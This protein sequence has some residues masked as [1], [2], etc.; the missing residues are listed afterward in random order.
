MNNSLRLR[1]TVWYVAFFSALFMLFSV[2]LYHT[3]ERDLDKRVNE[4]LTSE[5][6]TVAGF[7]AD[8]ID[9]LKGDVPAAAVETAGVRLGA[10]TIAIL[11][12][13]RVL[14]SAVPVPASLIE[15]VLRRPAGSG[16]ALVPLPAVGRRGSRAAVHPMRVRDREI[17]VLVTRP[18]DSIAADLDLVRRVL[19]FALPLLIAIAGAGGYLVASRSLAPLGAMAEQARRI[20]GSNLDTRLD[21][22]DAAAELTALAASFNELLSRLD[23]SFESMRRFVADAS[24]ELRTPLAVIRAEA[25]LTLDRERDPAEYRASL[26]VILDES[27]RLSRLIDDL[28]NLARADAGHVRLQ[29]EELD[30]NDLLSEC[31]RGMRSRAAAK[32]IEIECRPSAD[33]SFRGDREMLRRLVLNLLDNAIRYTPPGGRVSASLEPQDGAL[34][35]R[36]S[37]TGPGIPPEA[38]PH[39]FERFFRADQARSRADG[40]FGLG[41]AIVKWIAESHHGQVQW[42]SPAGGGA[43]FTV[44][45]PG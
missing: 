23:A 16:P 20:S 34:A 43:T 7:L 45:L 15:A 10:S 39:L 24:H 44:T 12:G 14:A 25:D 17:L 8:E 35:L 36:V 26:A 22:G 9:E 18:L 33:A 32:N 2:F 40:G 27:R 5:A 11:E 1:I 19:L 4:S 6:A 21:V 13:G 31:C 30:L 3:L 29:I 41:L 28:L 38:G 42:S 37:D